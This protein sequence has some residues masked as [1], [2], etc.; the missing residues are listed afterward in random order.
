MENLSGFILSVCAASMIFTLITAVVPQNKNS[1][2]LK[3]AAAAFLLLV[4]LKSAT[5]A[6]KNT[7]LGFLKSGSAQADTP[8]TDEYIEKTASEALREMIAKKLAKNGCEYTDLFVKVSY[9]D[10]NFCDIEV[11]L[12]VENDVSKRIASA[13]ADE[14]KLDFIITSGENGGGQNG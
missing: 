6:V 11:C 5:S 14:L 2:A 10:G 1:N 13:V 7:D 3:T 4:M 8:Y 12:T 9:D